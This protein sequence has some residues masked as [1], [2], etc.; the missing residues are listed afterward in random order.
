LEKRTGSSQ[1][2]NVLATA[3]LNGIEPLAW[4]TDTFT[5]LPTCPNSQI[6]SLL[7]LAQT[8]QD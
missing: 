5:K 4:L 6:D 3:K 7:P 1:D 2:L 8:Q